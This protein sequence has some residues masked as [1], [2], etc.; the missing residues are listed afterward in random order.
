[1]LDERPE[2]EIERERESPTTCAP[3]TCE[4]PNADGCGVAED[5][6]FS[7]GEGWDSTKWIASKLP[8]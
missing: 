3:L 8:E 1:M 5:Q 4:R 2:R 7:R 6:S